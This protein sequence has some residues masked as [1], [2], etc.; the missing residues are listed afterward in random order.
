MI[1][2]DVLPAMNKAVCAW[3]SCHGLVVVDDLQAAVEH[4]HRY[5]SGHTEAIITEDAEAAD[6]FL[7]MVDSAS[8]FHNASTRFADGY[9]YGL[10]AEVGISTGRIHARGPV[11]VDGL[12]TTRWLLRGSGQSVGEYGRGERTFLHRSLT[13]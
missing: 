12:M 8:V 3:P 2:M 10:G 11:G 13:V 5:G 1:V 9:R 7:T 4:I 6:R